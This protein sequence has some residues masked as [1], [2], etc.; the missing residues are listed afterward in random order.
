VPQWIVL[1]GVLEA[2]ALIFQLASHNYIQVVIT[3]SVKRAGIILTV[4]LGWL[5]FREKDRLV[6]DVLIHKKTGAAYLAVIEPVSSIPGLPR[7]LVT[8]RPPVTARPFHGGYG[9]PWVV[10]MASSTLGV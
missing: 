4:L 10:R 1:A 5:V 2:V 6:T 3:I 9:A 7:G 8:T